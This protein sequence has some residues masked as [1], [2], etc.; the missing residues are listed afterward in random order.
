[1]REVL[2]FAQELVLPRP[3]LNELWKALIFETPRQCGNIRNGRSPPYFWISANNASCGMAPSRWTYSSTLGTLSYQVMQLETRL[4]R[5][6]LASYFQHSRVE[7]NERPFDCGVLCMA[8][9]AWCER[10]TC[11]RLGNVE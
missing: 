4:E 5:S 10:I 2:I 6:L 11:E 1:M 7:L 8:L 9:H 3:R